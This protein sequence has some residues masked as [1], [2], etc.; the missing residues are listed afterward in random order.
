MRENTSSPVWE[1]SA[2]GFTELRSQGDFTTET[3]RTQSSEWIL[4]WP[5]V[6]GERCGD[7]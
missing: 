2:I 1:I 6:D 5:E 3:Q 4:N 7:A